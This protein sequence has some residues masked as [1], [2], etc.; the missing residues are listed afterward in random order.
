MATEIK[1]TRIPGFDINPNDVIV[2]D[3]L[4]QLDL[5]HG[6]C[7]TLVKDRVG[8]DQCP[9]SAYLQDKTCYCGLYVSIKK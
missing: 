3:V 9:C 6:H 5:N 8:H 1:I 4:K 2:N 7:P